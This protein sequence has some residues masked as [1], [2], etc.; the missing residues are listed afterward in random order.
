[1]SVKIH[2]LGKALFGNHGTFKITI[3]PRGGIEIAHAKA[4]R[5]WRYIDRNKVERENK[6][7]IRVKFTDL[8]LAY[9]AP[10][11]KE[12]TLFYLDDRGKVLG[13]D[14]FTD[15]IMVMGDDGIA[16]ERRTL[17]IIEDESQVKI[18]FCFPPLN[19]KG[20]PSGTTQVA[21]RF[22]QVNLAS[23]MI[24]YSIV[25]EVSKDLRI[26]PRPARR[27]EPLYRPR[28]AVL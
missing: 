8:L 5:D 27:A 26:A 20:V 1:M 11:F 28:S 17:A 13:S 9:L 25:C 12:C 7:K 22:E 21:F 19:G 6:V 3:T 18:R 23:R 15:W 16:R 14:K 4:F 2:H 10:D 24:K